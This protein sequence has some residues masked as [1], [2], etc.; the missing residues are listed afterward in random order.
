LADFVATAFVRIQ[1]ELEKG[2]RANLRKQIEKSLSGGITVPIKAKITPFR[3]A[4]QA[5]ARKTPIL[6]PVKPNVEIGK[7]RA[8]LKTQV[9]QAA[10]GVIVRIPVEA[11]TRIGRAGVSEKGIAAST[12]GTQQKTQADK[13]LAR[14]E[15]LLADLTD[16]R[17]AA[18]GRLSVALKKNLGAEFQLKQ[19]KAGMQQI[20]RGLTAAIKGEAAAR[21]AGNTALAEEL[22]LRQ[23]G[24]VS[25]G[26]R[27]NTE[28][29]IISNASKQTA[30][31]SAFAD[32]Q[33]TANAALGQN[34][35]AITSRSQ[36]AKLNNDLLA[37]EAD[38]HAVNKKA[39]DLENIAIQADTAA[40]LENITARQGDIVAQREQLAKT[41]ALRSKAKTAG[42]GGI[43]TALA[44]V[45][46]RGATLAAGGEFL[47][48]AA[49]VAI[50]AKAISS[51]ADL[52]KQLNILRVVSRAT[53]EEMEQV[54]VASLE[55]GRDVKLPGV[56][57]GDAAKSML[58]LVK[59]GLSVQ[60]AIDGAK[61][62]LQLA[63]AAEI[64]FAEAGT[65]VASAINAF[66]L[67]GTDA[68][69]VADLL[70]NAANESQAEI[71]DMG[72]SLQQSAA[73]A[74][75]VGVNLDD[76]V[77]LL[78]L[79]SR[80][81]LKGSDAGTSLRTAFIKLI[82]P[83]KRASSVL[84]QLNI[85]LRDTAGNI[86]P[87][88]FAEFE[89]ATSRLTRA[90]HD[91]AAAVVFGT[92]AI[93]AQALIGRQGISGLDAT[94]T[95]LARNGSAA[96]LAGAQAS[97]LSG[98]IS[99]LTSNLETLGTLL[100]SLTLG[101]LSLFVD[102]INELVS[103]INDVI[104]V[105]EKIGGGLA[106]IGKE[107][108]NSVPFLDKVLGGLKKIGIEQIK[109]SIDPTRR[110]RK[111]IA[112]AA[113]TANAL[114]GGRLGRATGLT[115]DT[116]KVGEAALKARIQVELLFRSI[117][118]GPRST[119]GE[120]NLNLVLVQL[121]KMADKLAKGD[122]E[123]QKVARS[124]REL[125]KE[126][127]KTGIVPSI[128]EIKARIDPNQ[129]KG[130]GKKGGLGVLSGFE[131]VLPDFNFLGEAMI[132]AL[133][134]GAEK[135]IAKLDLGEKFVSTLSTQLAVAE[136]HGSDAQVIA[137]LKKQRADAAKRE[138]QARVNPNLT[139]A[140]RNAQVAK[141]AADFEQADEAIATILEQQKI[142]SESA[143]R[144]IEGAAKDAAD[145]RE[146][147]DDAI[148]AGFDLNRTKAQNK[149]TIAAGT[150]GLADDIKTTIFLKKLVILQIRRIAEQVKTLKLR[151]AAIA[152]LV[153]VLF[154]LTQDIKAL[155]KEQAATIN[156]QIRT[157]LELD[158]DFFVTTGNKKAEINA[159]KKVIANIQKEIYLI[160]KQKHLTR[161]QK[162]HLKEL[163]NEIAEQ[164]AAIKAVTAEKKKSLESLQK[165]QFAFLQNVQGFTF[166]LLGNLIPG[167]ATGGLVGGSSSPSSVFTPSA[168]SAIKN[169]PSPRPTGQAA[170]D[171][172]RGVTS[173]QGNIQ[174]QL[175]R[176]IK[177]LLKHGNRGN[178]HPEAH[179][180][181]RQGTAALD[182]GGRGGHGVG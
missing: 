165:Q 127:T 3:K 68:V 43:A 115:K 2:F 159:R 133:S 160:K 101:P 135:A 93:R 110:P 153:Q 79:L 61:G 14:E 49:A 121:D 141:A 167:G 72:I 57:A 114:S 81:G 7:F 99:A 16:R 129:A 145:A 168:T 149:I 6:I 177:T 65:L 134:Q 108:A 70:T 147:I 88:V 130:E 19:A 158:V 37:V 76:T 97:G 173:T 87:E 28:K 107:A 63:T 17:S 4:L 161:E 69:H 136:A 15:A 78:T 120:S 148:L 125:V 85:D 155:R 58:L 144:D 86:R 67:R 82:N 178:E 50:T 84:K 35:K 75:L 55:L 109:N 13:A 26:A 113:R 74:S 8:A 171:K 31:T 11:G 52:Q 83:T 29:G 41:S 95:A 54:R 163:R 111:A 180:Q 53:A 181:R 128:A 142:D 104:I 182:Y 91:R 1:S 174:I 10:K 112:G 150:A 66:A 27:L 9:D 94:R 24:L 116:E 176:E 156:E 162:N 12:A 23:K 123:A 146:R 20:D 98:K 164:N 32:A 39:I 139:N 21:A 157:G 119:A 118:Q 179:R 122:S 62:T 105:T 92:D 132:D 103:G 33:K 25:L 59:A 154:G 102:T 138:A 140:Q 77:A 51:A 172:I 60:D 131:S 73:A 48:G 30:L 40:L 56:S 151:K 100:G 71:T 80:A 5:E 64:D 90:E 18:E 106:H 36:L 170:V 38:L 126:I 169:Q 34:V 166:S 46:A 175:L 47:A 89:Q 42:R 124:I 137:I 44:A 152:E 143:A 117:G 45:G 22:A 96:E